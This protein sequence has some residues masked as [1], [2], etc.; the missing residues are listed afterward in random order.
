MVLP[1]D[2][3]QTIANGGQPVFVQTSYVMSDSIVPARNSGTITYAPLGEGTGINIVTFQPSRANELMMLVPVG[4]TI[5]ML[6]TPAPG[7]AD[8]I[9]A[10][11]VAGKI[12]AVVVAVGI[13]AYATYQV[14]E[15]IEDLVVT[16]E[17]I[18]VPRS[19][20]HKPEHDVI[21][22]VAQVTAVITA[23]YTFAA[24]N[25][26][27][28]DNNDVRCI[29]M[30]SAGTV[31]RYIVWQKTF[32]NPTSLVAKGTIIIWH[33]AAPSGIDPWV[34]TYVNKSAQTL[35]KVPGDLVDDSLQITME[36]VGCG[37][38]PPP[39]MMPTGG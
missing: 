37:N 26:P 10:V 31:A 14:F 34:G 22:N 18:Y 3:P 13:T 29:I 20:E 17:T 15:G 25:P 38:F 36:E 6:D 8:V 12:V 23:L 7:P 1:V 32:V 30:R 24:T 9:A 2:D 21:N 28:G 35:L 4:G 19:P 5:A 39:P 11:Y 27:P 16:I 33:A